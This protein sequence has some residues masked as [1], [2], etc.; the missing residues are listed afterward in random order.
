MVLPSVTTTY[1]VTFGGAMAHSASNTATLT[2]QPSGSF[3]M[4]SNY[5]PGFSATG[6]LAPSPGSTTMGYISGSLTFNGAGL[7]QSEPVQ[8][9]V[10]YTLG[11][12]VSL[13]NGSAVI[14]QAQFAGGGTAYASFPFTG[15]AR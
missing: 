5:G 10:D 1:N 2:L 9:G 4:T 8:S 6:T 13:L 15:D 12:N 11:G 14:A 3:T 7:W